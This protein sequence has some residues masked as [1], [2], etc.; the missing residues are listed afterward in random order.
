MF[1]IDFT[2]SW[3]VLIITLALVIFLIYWLIGNYRN[4]Y[5]PNKIKTILLFLRIAALLIFIFLLTDLK[6][7]IH[8]PKPVKPEIAFL[9]DLS[10]SVALADSSYTVKTILN[11]PEYKDLA[12]HV[13]IKHIVNM[14]NPHIISENRLKQRALDEGITDYAKLIR[15]AEAQAVF[16]ELVLVSDGRSYWGE[17]IGDIDIDNKIKI[18][19]IGIGN[20]RKAMMPEVRALRYPPLVFDDDSLD[21]SWYLF[22]PSEETLTG[23]LS[24]TMD[25]EELF[26]QTV[27]IPGGRMI[28]LTKS[29][30]PT[31]AGRHN[32][33]FDFE[34]DGQKTNIANETITVLD[35]RIS[36]VFAD[37]PPDRDVAMMVTVLRQNERYKVTGQKLWTEMYGS[38]EPD[39]FIQTW[40]PENLPGIYNDI[41]SILIYR[42]K[43]DT[44]SY[45]SELQVAEQRP[46]LNID[47]DPAVNALYWTQL[48]PIQIA[49]L[50][51]LG[52]TV[53]KSTHDRPVIMEDMQQNAIII[54]GSGMWR[55]NLAGFDKEWDG[56]Y[57]HLINGITEKL[58][59]QF[60]RSYISLDEAIYKGMEYETFPVAVQRVD[61]NQLNDKNVRIYVT[62]FDSNYVE[63]NRREL[64]SDELVTEISFEQQGSYHVTADLFLGAKLMESDSADIFIEK[65]NME[66]YDPGCDEKALQKLTNDHRGYYLH[67]DDL[68]GLADMVSTERTWKDVSKVYIA[69][70]S[71]LLF[72]VMFL[73]LCAD[74]IIRKRSGGI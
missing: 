2:S 56:I 52:R 22:N 47:R 20:K 48:P 39:L 73:L 61:Q 3:P 65:N 19:A 7:E 63:I 36:V 69:R 18:H 17:K 32:W 37:D 72:A 70:H 4:T 41:P 8:R 46:Y 74:W 26:V 30:G 62:T 16:N 13:T 58:L 24:L 67:T 44:Y 1:D 66:T 50:K 12:K 21:M 38:K 43:N 60:G 53:L 14:R 68:N 31:E 23:E 54:N 10:Q 51:P 64:D 45:E 6:L 49:R 34:R 42:D 40:H 15:F 25:G 28:P 11:S 35:S 33:Q 71:Y 9:W 59:W 57:P 5:Y 29:F 27:S 55:W